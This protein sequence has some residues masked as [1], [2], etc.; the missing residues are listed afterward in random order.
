ML[1]AVNQLMKDHTGE[2]GQILFERGRPDADVP[3]D[4]ASGLVQTGVVEETLGVKLAEGLGCHH[5][6]NRRLTGG[7]GGA[8]GE[9][10][11][12]LQTLVAGKIAWIE[13]DPAG[14]VRHK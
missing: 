14:G 8:C 7:R 6:I 4:I 10:S 9:R 3:T 2:P 5:I 1:R 13:R 11:D 12:A